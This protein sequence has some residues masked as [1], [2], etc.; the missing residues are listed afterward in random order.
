M[1]KVAFIIFNLLISLLFKQQ[2]QTK[3]ECNFNKQINYNYDEISHLTI[4]YKDIFNQ[5]EKQYYVYFYSL[6][7]SHCFEIKNKIITYAL[8]DKV[9]TY[10]VLECDEIKYG[11]D[12]ELTIGIT[13]IEALFIKGYPSLIVIK[14]SNLTFNEA[15][16]NKILEKIYSS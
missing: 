2:L 16:I 9:K 13:S 5:K 10:F 11:F 15:G 14:N 6:I 3:S 1:K 12:T 4:Y 8:C 7:C